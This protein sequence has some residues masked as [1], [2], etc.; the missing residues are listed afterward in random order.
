MSCG[1]EYIDNLLDGFVGRGGM[2][3]R[4]GYLDGSEDPGGGGSSC[5]RS[6]RRAVY[7][8]FSDDPKIGMDADGETGGRV[9]PQAANPSPMAKRALCRQTLKVGAVCP[10]WAR[11]DLCGGRLVT[12]V[13]CTLQI[14]QRINTFC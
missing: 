2:R 11:T 12:A 3:L 8:R 14:A 9:S 1:G 4:A 7:G 13:P 10:N 6:V 5:W